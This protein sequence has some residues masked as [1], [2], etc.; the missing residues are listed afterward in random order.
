MRRIAADLFVPSS[1]S[2]YLGWS[3]PHKKALWLAFLSFSA[4]GLSLKTSGLSPHG[5]SPEA[6]GGAGRWRWGRRGRGWLPQ[7]KPLN[8]RRMEI[9]I[10][11]SQP[12]VDPVGKSEGSGEMAV[13]SFYLL[14]SL[15]LYFSPFLLSLVS[16]SP[17]PGFCLLELP[18]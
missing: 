6:C 7:E 4:S 12:P 10:K 8:Q 17:L 16:V 3:D 11:M 5:H 18:F 9:G 15:T 13:T 2:W 14:P 1:F